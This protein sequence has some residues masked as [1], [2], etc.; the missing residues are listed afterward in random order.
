MS[1]GARKAPET[2]AHSVMDIATLEAFERKILWLAAHTIHNANHGRHHDDG[3][4]VGGHQA[5]S[6]SLVTV[7]T[8]KE[9]A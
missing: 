3:I 1:A 2:A 9:E 4:K 6:A 5:S 7:M 8:A